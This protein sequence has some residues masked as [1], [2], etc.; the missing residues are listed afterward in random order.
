MA[1]GARL[2]YDGEGERAIYSGVPMPPLCSHW[3][4]C[5]LPQCPTSS[6][7]HYPSWLKSETPAQACGHVVAKLQ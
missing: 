4:D 1:Q 7:F 6:M 5:F 2:A 3:P